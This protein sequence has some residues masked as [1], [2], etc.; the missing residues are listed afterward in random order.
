MWPRL[1]PSF[2]L[3]DSAHSAPQI[4]HSI[5]IMTGLPLH[6]NYTAVPPGK[7]SSVGMGSVLD[8]VLRTTSSTV[9]SRELP[10]A[11]HQD[12]PLGSLGDDGLGSSPNCVPPVALTRA[13]PSARLRR[14]KSAL[15]WMWPVSP[16]S[17]GD[18]PPAGLPG[19]PHY[20]D[21]STY[22]FVEI[23]HP[24]MQGLDILV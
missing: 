24:C 13:P 21:S 6:R 18:M 10:Q 7:A 5:A 15:L 2:G 16:H 4:K 11:I 23:C 12:I 14:R 8:P 3:G 9:P 17:H 1:C 20:L 22:G 19:R